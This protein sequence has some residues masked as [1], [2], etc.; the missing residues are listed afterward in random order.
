MGF[1]AGD[2]ARLAARAHALGASGVY[3]LGE[4]EVGGFNALFSPRTPDLGRLTPGATRSAPA[5]AAAHGSRADR[6]AVT[7]LQ[8]AACALDVRASRRIEEPAGEGCLQLVLVLPAD[9]EAT[10]RTD[11]HQQVEQQIE[12]T[13]LVG[14][15]L[16][17]REH[18]EAAQDLAAGVGCAG[19]AH[20][21]VAAVRAARPE[22]AVR[23]QRVGP[24][25]DAVEHQ[26]Q[27]RAA[28]DQLRLEGAPRRR[29][30][31]A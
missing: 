2:R 5:A 19:R 25:L 26:Q 20:D 24:A 18:V 10:R 16:E 28:M 22:A 23:V 4:S 29:R 14:D 30:A 21:V 11:A 13:H 9:A 27:T 8:R 12:V 7:A 31:C 15:D 1:A 17:V 6:A 3:V